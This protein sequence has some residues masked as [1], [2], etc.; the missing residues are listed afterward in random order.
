MDGKK[1][2]GKKE[3]DRVERAKKMA[4]RIAVMPG[5]RERKRMAYRSYGAPV[6]A[7]GWIAKGM[8]AGGGGKVN[9]CRPKSREWQGP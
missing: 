4:A 7:Y 9:N 6:Q 3:Q 8:P 1:K 5:A 2:D